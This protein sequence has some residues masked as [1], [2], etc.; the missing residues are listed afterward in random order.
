MFVVVL[1]VGCVGVRT[2]GL[3]EIR[4]LQVVEWGKMTDSSS[5]DECSR[6]HCIAPKKLS[7]S[8]G[9]CLLACLCCVCVGLC[10][11]GLLFV[12]VACV[13]CA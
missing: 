9:V 1:V 8:G 13:C 10:F 12:V 11:C 3:Q 4:V 7:Q 2:A 6:K 5:P